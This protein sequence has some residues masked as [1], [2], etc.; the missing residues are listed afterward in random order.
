MAS[1]GFF[2]LRALHLERHVDHHNGV[3]LYQPDQQDDA[4]RPNHVEFVV[5]QQQGQQC[6]HAGRRNRR[7]NR[8]GMNVALIEHAQHD[9]NRN[10]GGN[11]QDRSLESESWNAC[12][13]PWKLA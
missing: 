8:D 12:A 7:E 10:Q 6:A 11:N 1:T 9:V 5:R 13:V 4:D 3:L 2:P